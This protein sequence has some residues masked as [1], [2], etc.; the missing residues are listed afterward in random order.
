MDILFTIV[1]VVTLLGNIGLI[2]VNLEAVRASVEAQRVV[3]EAGKAKTL[4]EMGACIT[5]LMLANFVSIL[6]AVLR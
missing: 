4:L 3:G 2:I 6:I 5:T 1:L